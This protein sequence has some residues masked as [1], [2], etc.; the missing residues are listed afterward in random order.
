M[1]EIRLT[2]MFMPI[3]LQV[4]SN[5]GGEH[6]IILQRTIIGTF[7]FIRMPGPDAHQLADML[8]TG[9]ANAT[10]T[11]AIL[12]A[13]G[14]LHGIFVRALGTGKIRIRV[15]VK[16]SNSVLFAILTSVGRRKQY[17]NKPK[18]TVDEAHRFAAALREANATS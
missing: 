1:Q 17:N 2:Y 9:A 10:A 14:E 5:P 8:E 6:V 13:I 7:E 18:L 11:P 12:G 15:S 3:R 4:Q 16:R